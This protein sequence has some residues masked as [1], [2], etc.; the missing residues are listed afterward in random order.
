MAVWI[1][2]IASNKNSLTT[3]GYLLMSKYWILAEVTEREA[4]KRTKI[5]KRNLYK[6]GQKTLTY[7][8]YPYNLYMLNSTTY[9][10]PMTISIQQGPKKCIIKYIL[11]ATN[12]LMST[13]VT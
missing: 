11:I 9:N 8:S 5:G 1:R 4:S 10:T 6:T 2:R 3:V 12:W 13:S 7:V